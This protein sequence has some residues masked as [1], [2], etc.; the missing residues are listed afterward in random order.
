MSAEIKVSFPSGST[1]YATVRNAAGNVWQVAGQVF[2]A[3]GTAGRDADDYDIVLTGDAGDIYVGDMDSNIGSGRYSVQAYIRDTGTPIDADDTV[4]A[5]EI[6]WDGS[7][8]QTETEFE[9]NNVAMVDLAAGAPSATA[10]I[11]SAINYLY[12]AWRNK[13]VTNGSTDEVQIFKDDGA[14]IL[15]E[16]DISDD[17]TSFS[18]AEYGAE[19]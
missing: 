14:T 2:E 16:A 10:S 11:L 18:K 8:E 12:E 7:A 9:L 1:L 13:T 3:W 19:D 5:D 6:W 4:G 15:C 17:G